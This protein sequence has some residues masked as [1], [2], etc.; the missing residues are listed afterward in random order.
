M[1][2]SF[3]KF[4]PVWMILMILW[5][6][7]AS[8]MF[9]R[10]LGFYP[11]IYDRP[12]HN[13]GYSFVVVV[14]VCCSWSQ[15]GSHSDCRLSGLNC[16]RGTEKRCSRTET[17]N[18]IHS[19]EAAI[20]CCILWIGSRAF[21]LLRQCAVQFLNFIF[22]HNCSLAILTS[23]V[24]LSH[25]ITQMWQCLFDLHVYEVCWFGAATTDVIQNH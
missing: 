10:L 2:A 17:L 21:G 19:G 13:E 8:K 24:F 25:C 1:L 9:D 3:A 7:M 16:S 14:S 23:G 5:P 12:Q 15:S 4:D 18:P 11:R 6:T 22:D 20:V